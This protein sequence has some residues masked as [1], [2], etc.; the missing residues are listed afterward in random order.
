M[1]EIKGIMF[2]GAVK[3]VARLQEED[4]CLPRIDYKPSE[5]MVDMVE[6]E[7]GNGEIYCKVHV[8]AARSRE[9]G[10]RIAIKITEK[11][12]SR[13][14]FSENLVIDRVRLEHDGLGPLMLPS[15]SY[16]FEPGIATVTASSQASL[17]HK[18]SPEQVKRQA[19]EILTH[20]FSDL[21]DKHYDLF[22]A[23]ISSPSDVEQFLLLYQLLPRVLGI[24]GDNQQK[25][26]NYIIS[27]LP[28]FPVGYQSKASPRHKD[29]EETPF[30]RL[31]NEINHTRIDVDTGEH[32]D[33][34][35]T[36]R[37]IAE[38]VGV[39]RNLVR[40]AIRDQAK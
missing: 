17:I 33:L 13:I 38:L 30:T 11:C 40:E 12:L 21:T 10:K 23:A 5:A 19:K 26:D 1:K 37:Q 14:A 15:G 35:E 2:G 39:F 8:V 18:R 9:D 27:K 31:R 28:A 32:V 20:N 7:A 4:F 29:R 34:W 16:F 6:I 36:K 24:K 3:L 22:R 25:I